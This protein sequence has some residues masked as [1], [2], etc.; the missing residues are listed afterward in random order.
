MFRAPEATL[1]GKRGKTEG[2]HYVGPTWESKD[3]ST[4]VGSKLAAF[5]ADAG[6]DPGAAPRRRVAHG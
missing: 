1:Y 4:V 6:F 5:T 3:G 2:K